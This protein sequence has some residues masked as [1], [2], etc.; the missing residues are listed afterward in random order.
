MPEGFLAQLMDYR[1]QYSGI[2][3][4]GVNVITTTGGEPMDIPHVLAQG[5]AAL[6]AEAG[7]IAGND[8]TFQARTL[9]AYKYGQL[10]N[11]SRELL[12]DQAVNLT[13]WLAKDMGRALARATENHYAVGTGTNQPQGIMA[14]ASTSVT[15]ANGNAGVPTMDNLLTLKY[16]LDSLYFDQGAGW[17][18]NHETVA[19]IAALRENGTSGAYLWQPNNIVDEP[20]RLL[21]FPVYTSSGVPKAA[22]STKSIIFANFPDAYII[23]DAGGVRLE[24]SDDYLFGTDEVSF[25]A[26]IRTDGRGSY[27]K[28]A[29][30]FTGGT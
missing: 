11:V 23:R 21:G 27:G 18:M 7:T 17:L 22:A 16:A 15:G 20:E 24:R 14:A 8:P 2:R 12:Q 25:K 29:R 5:T 1:E 28:A 9:G 26:V 3:M 10:V 13:S 4:A 6:T 30:A 19:I